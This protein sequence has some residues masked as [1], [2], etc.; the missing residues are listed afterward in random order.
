MTL[1]ALNVGSSAIIKSVAL[2]RLVSMGFV[3]GAQ[4][5]VLR[6]KRGCLHVR[7]GLTEWAIRKSTAEAVE[8][9]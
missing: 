7:V 3:V 1:N 8:L 4:V 9:K 2:E 6:Q 5:T